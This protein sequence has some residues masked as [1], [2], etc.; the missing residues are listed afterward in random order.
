MARLAILLCLLLVFSTGCMG[1]VEETGTGA[2][3]E[4]STPVNESA[5]AGTSS[6]EAETSR[7][8]LAPNSD[9][10][11]DNIS[12]AYERDVGTDPRA[13]DT[14]E[15][16][17]GDRAELRFQGMVD[18]DPTTADTDGDGVLDGD[19]DPDGD[20]LTNREEAEVGTFP[21]VADS[22]GDELDDDVELDVGTKPMEP[23]TDGD[24]LD[25][26]VE[27]REPFETDPLVS[28]TDGDGVSDGDE[29]YTT[30]TAYEPLDT[31]VAV[32]GP[33][34]VAKEVVI[35]PPSHALTFDR[36][37]QDNLP[38]APFVEVVIDTEFES[39]RIFISYNESDISTAE[40][41]I[42]AVRL[43]ETVNLYEVVSSQYCSDS[44]EVFTEN[45]TVAIET[46][47]PG[48]YSIWDR[49]A[50]REQLNRREIVVQRCSG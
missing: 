41:N 34:N 43:N 31:R 24:G 1:F 33:G 32:T 18:V 38:V 29:M 5:D 46:T 44:T 48:I 23:D 17:L 12:T 35:R 11:G 26:G 39:A 19:E 20:G 37:I 4:S 25:D 42:T 2:T 9:P 3:N 21:D 27:R 50:L 45:N 22:D 14:D 30:T 36:Y 49:S 40:T 13:E 47:E 6:D 28:D 15:D 8:M 7:E 10:D 16:N